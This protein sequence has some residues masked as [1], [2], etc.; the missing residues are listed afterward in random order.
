MRRDHL[1]FYLREIEHL[2]GAYVTVEGRRMLMMASYSYL[3]LIGHPKIQEAASQALRQYG[4]G[5]HGVR[6]L[7]G[8]LP[9]HRQLEEEI[10]RFK[11]TEAAIAFASGYGTNLATI[12]TLVGRNDIVICDKLD[13]A[14]I[15]DGCQLSGARF[16]RFSHNDADALEEQLERVQGENCGKLV[17]VDAVY[18]MDGDVAPLPQLVDL[19]QRYG[20]W[21]MVDEAHS[22]GVLGKT[23]TG[24]EEHFSLSGSI[25]IKMGTLSKTIP[26]VGGY[27]A[28]RYDLI[29]FLKLNA[30][31]FVFSA[32]LPPPAAAAALAAFQVIREEPWRVERVQANGRFFKEGLESLGFNTFAAQTSVVPILIGE[33]EQTLR[34]TRFLQDEGLFVLPVLPPAVPPHTA[35]LRTT[36]TAA[37]SQADIEMALDKIGKAKTRFAL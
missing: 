35:R 10:A 19:C 29:D 17:I 37:H 18:S 25:P 27:I 11:G 31:S 6:V 22:L 5:T 3:G 24:I 4:T 2:D 9:I 20:A 1:Y 34:V 36:V 33:E 32:A 13:H 7:A 28:G 26:S 15:V 12:S 30:R 8:S 14:S 21:I 16:L 23:G